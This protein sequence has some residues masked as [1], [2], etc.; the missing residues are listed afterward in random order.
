[1]GLIVDITGG[2][3]DFE[4]VTEM[5]QGAVLADIVDKGIVDNK[6]KPGT[7][8]H[9][10]YFVWITAEEDSEGR[11]KRV[12]E[13]FTMSLNE[14]ATLRKRLKE[15]GLTDAAIEELKR[16]KEGLDLE[17]Y[18]GVKRYLV[19][20]EEDGDA[21][22]KFIKILATKALGKGQTAP[23]VPSDFV[24]AVDREQK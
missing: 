5:L 23:D 16:K 18:L 12:F 6:F 1:V 14:K 15:F 4:P 24:R 20:S 21:G 7:K 9:K 11:N 13:S 2:G 17:Q 3:K 10:C 22:K 19:M 8:Q